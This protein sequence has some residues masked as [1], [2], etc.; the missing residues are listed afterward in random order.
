MS[1][2][3]LADSTVQYST[4]QY[5]AVQYSAVYRVWVVAFSL[6][7]SS[8]QCFQHVSPFYS[9]SAFQMTVCHLQLDVIE[10]IKYNELLS[11]F[12]HLRGI[13]TK[14]HRALLQLSLCKYVETFI[15]RYVRCIYAKQVKINRSLHSPGSSEVHRYIFR[16][17]CLQSLCYIC[18]NIHTQVSS[19]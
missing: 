15:D 14:F 19:N 4:V 13:R 6:H 8:H 3:C 5:S 7:Y 16:T 17:S 18:T 10:P 2:I 12:L 9:L 11:L 1:I